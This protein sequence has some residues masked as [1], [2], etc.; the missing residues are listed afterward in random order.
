MVYSVPEEGSVRAISRQARS[1]V[2]VRVRLYM[3]GVIH[4]MTMS[5]VQNALGSKKDDVNVI[6]NLMAHALLGAITA[7]ANGNGALAGASGAVV[8]EYI[9]QQ[10][11]PGVN[12]SD[13]SEEQKQIISTLSTLA[14]C[15]AEG[16][17]K[18]F[19]KVYGL[20][21]KTP[22]RRVCYLNPIYS[23]KPFLSSKE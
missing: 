1:K 9:A 20:P 6:A 18:E 23:T 8:S 2:N 19:L 5:A 21:E 15:L 22:D 4:D 11:Y 13:L 16:M 12:R 3:A 14:A 10:L 17:P 7:Q